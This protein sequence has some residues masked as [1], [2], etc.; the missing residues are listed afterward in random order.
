MRLRKREKHLSKKSKHL[1]KKPMEWNQGV[2]ALEPAKMPQVLHQDVSWSRDILDKMVKQVKSM[3]KKARLGIA[4]DEYP[5][6]DSFL[7]Y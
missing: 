7:Q 5:P 4:I 1:G 6:C 2:Q 3:R